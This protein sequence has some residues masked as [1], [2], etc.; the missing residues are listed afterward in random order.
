[1]KHMS[2]RTSLLMFGT[3]Q[4]VFYALWKAETS[5]QVTKT[6]VA[7]NSTAINVISFSYTLLCLSLQLNFSFPILC[8]APIIL[9]WNNKNSLK[10]PSQTWFWKGYRLHDQ[11]QRNSFSQEDTSSRLYSNLLVGHELL[12][13]WRA[14]T[15][16]NSKSLGWI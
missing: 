12:L 14:N 1:M 9:Q 7:G 2:I 10:R 15:K 13:I 6:E 11:F 5:W 8:V 3:S 16:N 4:K